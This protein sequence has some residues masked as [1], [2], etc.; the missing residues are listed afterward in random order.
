MVSALKFHF[1]LM[2]ILFA[3]CLQFTI[4][5]VYEISRHW[6]W[7]LT[8]FNDIFFLSMDNKFFICFWQR[9]YKN[10]ILRGKCIH[11]IYYDLA[12]MLHL[13]HTHDIFLALVLVSVNFI[14]LSSF[15]FLI[16]LGN[17][18]LAVILEPGIHAPT[19]ELMLGCYMFVS[20]M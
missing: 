15:L 2:T 14:G 5:L 17:G 4:A 20:E 7:H 1:F 9:I 19:I 18:G 16:Y 10:S 11:Y 8:C 3:L 6:E 13:S 12:V